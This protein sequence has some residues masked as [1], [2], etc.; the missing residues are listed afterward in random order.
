MVLYGLMTLGA[1]L[2]LYLGA[3]VT[4]V[5]YLAIAMV[6]IGG[7]VGSQLPIATAGEQLVQTASRLG[8]GRHVAAVAMAN[9]A[10]GGGGFAE[11]LQPGG[12][13]AVDSGHYLCDCLAGV[14]VGQEPP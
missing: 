10:G 14:A 1:G 8:N 11:P 6:S 5:F 9:R 3:Q 12:G 13:P 2:V 4:A 7:V